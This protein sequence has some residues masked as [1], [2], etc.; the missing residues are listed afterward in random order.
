MKKNYFHVLIL[1]SVVFILSTV[2]ACGSS[3]DETKKIKAADSG[4]T[5]QTQP[6]G[7]AQKDAPKDAAG[8]AAQQP[9]VPG[10]PVKP[11][12]ASSVVAQVDDVTLTKGQL[13]KEVEKSIAGLGNK[14]PQGKMTEAKQQIRRQIVDDFVV[15]TLLVKEVNRLKIIANEQE[16]HQAITDLRASVP[17][18][19]TFDEMLAQKGL[20]MERLRQ[21]VSL[22]I[23]INKLVGQQPA[24]KAKPTD[25]E[26]NAFYKSNREK[27]K[28]PEL[29]HARHI[30]IGIKADEDEAS[31][32]K[33]REKAEEIRKKLVAG[34]DFAEMA[35]SNSDCPS[36]TNGGD[37]GSFP[38]GQ[39]VKPFDD[40]AFTQKTNEI[41]PVVQTN[42]GYH[43]IQVL[44]H[45]KPKTQPLDKAVKANISTFLVQQKRYSAFNDLMNQLKTKSKITVAEKME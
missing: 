8:T 45:T 3:T 37:L 28:I 10:A 5:A 16:M 22:G 21:E 25:K 12:T 40:A 33:K 42:F 17:S 39:M 41:G 14:I 43:I 4:Q 26:I 36:K 31:K 6:P 15:R 1:F 18:G 32:A 44:E 35:K 20:T 19:V 24:A 11:L 30:L 23:R 9:G 7:D 29:V 2:V 38:R 27:F 13:D 34:A